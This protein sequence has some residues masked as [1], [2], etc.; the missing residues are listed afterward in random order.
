[1]RVV[2]LD[3]EELGSRW[4]FVCSAVPELRCVDSGEQGNYVLEQVKA[5]LAV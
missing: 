3:L 1:M 4:L 5:L 2:F